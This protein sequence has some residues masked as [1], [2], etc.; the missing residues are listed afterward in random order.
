M[1]FSHPSLLPGV[2]GASA[3]LALGSS[4]GGRIGAG[5]PTASAL[6]VVAL[7]TPKLA[8]PR[9]RRRHDL[10]GMETMAQGSAAFPADRRSRIGAPIRHTNIRLES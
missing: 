3:A 9:A 5:G 1:P 7:P 6:R 4:S 2:G 10:P 8:D